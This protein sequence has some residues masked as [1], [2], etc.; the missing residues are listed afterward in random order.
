MTESDHPMRTY[1]IAFEVAGPL[2]MFARPDTGATPTSYPV[3]T[4]S[5]AKGVFESIAFLSDGAA[6]ICPTSVAVCRPV[7][8]PGGRVRFQKYTNNY[9][10]PLRKD[11]LFA[12]GS[13]QG[14]SSMQLFATVLSDVCYRLHATVVGPPPAGRVNARHFLQDLFQRRLKQGRCFRTPC[15]GWSELTCSY[16]GPFRHGVTEIDE[17]LHL[18]VPS[19]LLGVWDDPTSGRYAPSFRQDVKVV[20]GRLS[21]EFPLAGHPQNARPGAEVADAQ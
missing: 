5:A 13:A 7:G 6:W 3:P 12:K 21:Y 1:E 10:G 11:S 19:M 16:W 8:T 2:A 20:G 4:W 14:G 17:A 15:L 18:E 9:G